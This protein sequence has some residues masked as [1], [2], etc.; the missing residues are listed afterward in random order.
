MLM[1]VIRGTSKADG[2]QWQ[3]KTVSTRTGQ[4]SLKKTEE[5]DFFFKEKGQV[6]DVSLPPGPSLSAWLFAREARGSK[7]CWFGCPAGDE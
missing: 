6:Q 5:S 3:D 4:T 1:F 7:G 2:P